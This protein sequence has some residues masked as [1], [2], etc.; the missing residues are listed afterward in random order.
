MGLTL[1]HRCQDLAKYSCFRRLDFHIHLVG[2]DFEVAPRPSKTRSPSFLSHLRIVPSSIVWPSMGSNI[3]IA[4][5]AP[6]FVNANTGDIS[7]NQDTP[8]AHL[9]ASRPRGKR[10]SKKP[11]TKESRKGK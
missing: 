6:L 9:S 4:I 5:I 3:F 1:I 8:N 10:F 7:T 2:H 11:G